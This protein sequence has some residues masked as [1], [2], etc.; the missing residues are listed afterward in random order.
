MKETVW[1]RQ[2][3]RAGS[4]R[5]PNPLRPWYR[6]AKELL[7]KSGL[8]SVNES[9]LDVGCG[10]GEFMIFLK[11]MG[12]EVEGIDGNE[13][14]IKVVRSLGLSG[15]LA[16]LEG[17]LPYS[18]QSFSLVTCLEVLEHIA[19]AEDLLSEIHRVLRPAGCLLLSTPNFS[20][21]NNRFHYLLGAAPCNEGVHLR[22]LVKERLEALLT[23]SAFKIIGRNSYGVVPFLS[24]LT[25]RLLGGGDVLRRIPRSLESFLAYDFVYLAQKVDP[26]RCASS[27]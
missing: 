7:S 18:D 23:R 16:D 14:Q 20:F 24:T 10:V 19:N 5:H 8:P 11:A 6:Y 15:K 9:A 27:L 21:L 26:A 25:T 1:N 13:A 22:F 4:A 12:F 17:P 2:L 3:T